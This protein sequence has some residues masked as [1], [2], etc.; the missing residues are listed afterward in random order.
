MISAIKARAIEK[1]VKMTAD[2]LD[3]EIKAESKKK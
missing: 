2:K 3:Q 1:I